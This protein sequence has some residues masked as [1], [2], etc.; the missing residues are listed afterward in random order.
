[1]FVA[2]WITSNHLLF[3][4]DGSNPTR[5]FGFFHVR[6]L[7]NRTLVL[8]PEVFLQQKSWKVAI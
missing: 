6:K 4:D 8:V 7:A 5:D 1:M 3:T 2:V